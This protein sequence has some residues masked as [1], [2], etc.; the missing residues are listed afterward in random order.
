[1]YIKL[2]VKICSVENIALRIVV[3]LKISLIRYLALKI[4]ALMEWAKLINF[5]KY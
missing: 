1:M 4:M 5:K 3:I 2:L